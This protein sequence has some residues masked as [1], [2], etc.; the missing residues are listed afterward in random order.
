MTPSLQLEPFVFRQL[1]EIIHERFGILLPEEKRRPE[2]VAAADKALGRPLKVLDAQI[3][4][5]DWLIGDAFTIADLNVASVL[6]MSGMVGYDIA[7]YANV[8]RWFDACTAR[9]SFARAQS[10]GS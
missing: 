9:P 8:K 1:Q 10:P 2:M 7:P 4:G 6:M 3:E 5:R